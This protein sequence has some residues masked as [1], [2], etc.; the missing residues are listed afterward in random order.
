MSPESKL[1]FCK[2]SMSR[3]ASIKKPSWEY[4]KQRQNEIYGSKDFDVNNS[5]VQKFIF[6]LDLILLLE[7]FSIQS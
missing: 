4:A 7:A 3:I 2:G 5:V 1:K 6:F